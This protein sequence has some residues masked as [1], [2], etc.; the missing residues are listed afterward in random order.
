[1]SETEGNEA[2]E[3]IALDD[4]GALLDEATVRVQAVVGDVAM[5]VTRLSGLKV[6]ELLELGVAVGAPVELRLTGGQRV[7]SGELVDVEGTL[8]VRVRSIG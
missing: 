4:A 1:M 8:G 6:G 7:G 2:A 5:S 3:A